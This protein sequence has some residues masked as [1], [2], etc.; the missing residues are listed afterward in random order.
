MRQAF[1]TFMKTLLTFALLLLTIPSA[2]GEV[3]LDAILN[4]NA[5]EIKR[6]QSEAQECYA[7][8]FQDLDDAKYAETA[9]VLE[10]LIVEYGDDPAVEDAFFYLADIYSDRLQGP[11]NFRSAIRILETFKEKHPSSVK[12]L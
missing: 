3:N 11:D 7:E 2:A 10:S 12:Y 1:I 5:E 9:K 8:A 4:P 6:I